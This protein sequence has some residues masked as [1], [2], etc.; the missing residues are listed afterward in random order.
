[1]HSAESGGFPLTEAYRFSESHGL[2]RE[3]IAIREMP[4]EWTRSY[5]TGVRKGRM[6]KLLKEKNLLIPFVEQLWPYGNSP[7]GQTLV[8]RHI[9][10]WDEYKKFRNGDKDSNEDEAEDAPSTLKFALEAH[11]RDFLAKNLER[12]EVGLK[13]Y[14][15]DGNDGIEFAAGDG[16]IDLLA[17]DQ[18]GKFVVIELK[19]SLGRQKTLGQLLYYMG[20]VDEHLGNGPCRGLIV[21]SEISEG[22]KVAVSRTPG[23]ILAQYNMAFSVARV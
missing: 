13:L 11:L 1:M 14:E 2:E 17:V 9:R 7:R 10:I 20:W 3:S 12:I 16:R 4:I 8:R 15:N 19:L 18:T 5:T 21:A 23:V 6:I 22:L